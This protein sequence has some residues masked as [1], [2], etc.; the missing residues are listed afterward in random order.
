MT[1]MDTIA[2]KKMKIMVA[3]FVALLVAPF[4]VVVVL[5]S[6]AW[7]WSWLYEYFMFVNA[8][9]DGWHLLVVDG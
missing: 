6:C 3:L 4:D 8:V 2:A 5:D 1:V 9:V 7:L